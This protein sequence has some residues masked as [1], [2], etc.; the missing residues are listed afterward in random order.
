MEVRRATPADA[1]LIQE[2]NRDVQ[3]LHADA[4]PHLFKQPGPDTCSPASVMALMANPDVYY[5]VVSTAAGD[6]VGYI[7]A[8]IVHR[9]E[10]PL[11]YALDLVYIHQ[12]AVKPAYRRQGYARRLLAEVRR[13]AREHGISR[14]ELDFWSFN[15]GAR[16]L[17]ASEGMILCMERMVLEL[18]S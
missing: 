17:Y 2:L 5:Y 6:P 10:T 3:Q 7:Y 13:L 14:I 4:Y 18:D 12:I 16:A 8:Q 15:A 11:R 9:A 1:E